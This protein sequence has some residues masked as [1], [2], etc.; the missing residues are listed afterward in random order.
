[1]G[2]RR[3]MKEYVMERYVTK[4][5][6]PKTFFESCAGSFP[7]LARK[8][9]LPDPQAFHFWSRRGSMPWAVYLA[10]LGAYG[11]PAHHRPPQR[12]QGARGVRLP[13]SFQQFVDGDAVS[14][15]AGRPIKKTAEPAKV[16]LVEAPITV[17]ETPVTPSLGVMTIRV[18]VVSVPHSLPTGV[19]NHSNGS[20]A[21]APSEKEM[22]YMRRIRE[23]EQQ[24]SDL[25]AEVLKA[26][27]AGRIQTVVRTHP[28][29]RKLVK[30]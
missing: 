3:T 4:G 22:A 23:L 19:V 5:I 12:V 15:K 11:E 6:D 9:N 29:L 2:S 28:E 18:E 17:A 13:L 24:V 16:D 27:P 1:V 10:L 26:T 20:V 25:R 7:Q 21:A 14:P 8:I 30:T